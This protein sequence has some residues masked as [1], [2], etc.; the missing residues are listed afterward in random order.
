MT[1]ATAS[2]T[3]KLNGQTYEYDGGFPAEL[4]E[5]INAQLTPEGF[6]RDRPD[7]SGECQDLEDCLPDALW[8][9]RR[10]GGIVLE[11]TGKRENGSIHL[12]DWKQARV[13]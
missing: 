13:Y 5:Q 1:P 8:E 9:I 3:F 10:L 11:I 7:L 12:E 2:I 6:W 4:A